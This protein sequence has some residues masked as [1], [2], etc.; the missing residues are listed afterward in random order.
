MFKYF[1]FS[2]RFIYSSIFFK[3]TNYF[4]NLPFKSK[5]GTM[6][7]VVSGGMFKYQEIY[8]YTFNN[9]WLLIDSNEENIKSSKEYQDYQVNIIKDLQ[10]FN[11]TFIDNNKY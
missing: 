5:P 9:K 11:S 4:G 2:I 10:N 8:I 1:L 7:R 3:T 6:F